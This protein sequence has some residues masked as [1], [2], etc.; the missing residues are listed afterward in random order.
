[1]LV[2]RPT[3]GG[4]SSTSRLISPR[5][6][7]PISRTAISWL[8]SRL[9]RVSGSPISLLKFPWV[10]KALNFCDRTWYIMSLQVVFPVDPVTAMMSGLKIFKY[11]LLRVCRAFR[12]SFVYTI[13]VPTG[14]PI[15][16]SWVR[17]AAAPLDT[18]SSINLW[19]LKFSPIKGINKSPAFIVRVSVDIPVIFSAFPCRTIRPSMALTISSSLRGFIKPSPF[20]VNQQ[21]F[22]FH[23]SVWSYLLVFDRSHGP[24][25]P[26]SINHPFGRS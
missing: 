6:L 20:Q 15:F 25:L 11:Q 18:A 12:V 5:S 10:F 24:C 21:Q 22:P 26:V 2:I 14:K 13:W 16:S 23:Q 1:M 19:P 4:A 9:N 17:M 7:I 8:E 3:F